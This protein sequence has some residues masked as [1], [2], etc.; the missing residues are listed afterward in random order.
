MKR[1]QTLMLFVALGLL[2]TLFAAVACAGD[3]AEET[4]TTTTTAPT[5]VPPTPTAAR[6]VP[7]SV[8]PTAMPAATAMPAVA[9][10]AMP[11]T[12]MTDEPMGPKQGGHVNWAPSA[13]IGSLD[14]TRNT[15]TVVK[16][17]IRH[18]YSFPF[19]MNA[20]QIPTPQFVTNWSVTPDASEYTFD[21]R[22]DMTFSGQFRAPAPVTIDDVIASLD[23]WITQVQT[24]GMLRDQ[25]HPEWQAVDADT[26]KIIANKPFGLW[27]DYWAL[28]PESVTWIIPKA[29]LDEVGDEETLTDYTG[30]GPYQ[31]VAWSPGARIDLERHAAYIPRD[32]PTS[33]F[34]GARLSY[35]DTISFLEVPDAATKVAGLQTGQIDFVERVPGDFYETL[36]NE[37]NLQV[38]LFHGA[39]QA[40][41]NT[42]KL[43]PPMND[44]RSRL[45]I[46]AATDV[47][48]YMAIYGDEELWQ[49]CGAIF[50][51]GTTWATEAHTENYWAEP[52]L[53]KARRLWQE[54][55][56]AT[57]FE[58]KIV[59]LTNTDLPDLYAAAL[60]TKRI[61][62]D[63]GAEVEFVVTDWG[64][65][66]SRKVANLD[67]P[68]DQGG[69]HLY[70]GGCRCL[71]PLADPTIGKTWN[72]GWGNERGYKLVEDFAKAKTREEAE[73]IVAEI[74]RIFWEED[75]PNPRYG[76][77][78]DINA[79]QNYVMNYQTNRPPSME[80]VWLDK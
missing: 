52:D 70:Q 76:V 38:Q 72:G 61:L 17:V 11:S 13:S 69:W 8:A 36:L 2:M 34:A 49:L 40:M 4:T 20:D 37:E 68:P 64:A 35:L 12:T 54:A 67:K 29:T 80:G 32:E 14:P 59:L 51:C 57:G 71:D 47:K 63:I 10:T 74:Q 75:P 31:Y 65:L 78:A 30:S 42:N 22:T 50:V 21:I 15:A 9:P 19:E 26:F 7:P 28:G 73:E 60:I 1:T 33:G 46:V 45:A 48:E 62:E 77:Y 5:T 23:R 25:A 3:E 6:A 44:P 79:M 39:G 18:W 66:I 27:V 16:H 24:P 55:V 43:W 53:E 41:L 56:D 58:G